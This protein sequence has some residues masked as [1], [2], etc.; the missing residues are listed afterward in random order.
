MLLEVTEPSRAGPPEGEVPLVLSSA[1][2]FI[3]ASHVPSLHR[4]WRQRPEQDLV[5]TG[6]PLLSGETG[7]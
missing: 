2:M 5:R 3:E 6:P 7:R 4:P 1:P